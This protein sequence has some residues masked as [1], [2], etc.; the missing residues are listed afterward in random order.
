MSEAPPRKSQR[1]KEVVARVEAEVGTVRAEYQP[2]AILWQQQFVA[3]AQ[4]SQP[5]CI[6]GLD[7][8]CTP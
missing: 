4:V 1:P 5:P 8:R 6:P 3:L 7:P 2:P